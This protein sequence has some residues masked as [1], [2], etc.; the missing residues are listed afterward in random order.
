M[1][2]LFRMASA[3][4]NL[5]SPAKGY[6][7][8]NLCGNSI[9]DANQFRRAAADTRYDIGVNGSPYWVDRTSCQGF[10]CGDG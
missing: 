2:R 5:V 7:E 8:V 1:K 3:P 10:Q 6:F 4:R 9:L